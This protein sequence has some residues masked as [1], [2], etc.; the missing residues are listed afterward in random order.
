MIKNILVDNHNF[1]NL[2]A[3]YLLLGHTLETESDSHFV[4]YRLDINFGGF[5]LVEASLEKG[6]KNALWSFTEYEYKF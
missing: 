3:D 6:V 4:D 1:S 2:E 5:T